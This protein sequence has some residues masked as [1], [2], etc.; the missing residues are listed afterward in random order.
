MQ[1]AKRSQ[2]GLERRVINFI[3][4]E[5]EFDPFVDAHLRDPLHIAEARAERQA[6]Q[7]MDD[8]F[9]RVHLHRHRF[10]GGGLI[11]LSAESELS[12]QPGGHKHRSCHEQAASA[13]RH[14]H[15]DGPH[16]K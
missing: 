13:Q 1:R 12:R 3:G 5:F 10:A 8:T 15:P 11:F 16:K 14:S 2:P 7:G 4:M 9:P 6:V